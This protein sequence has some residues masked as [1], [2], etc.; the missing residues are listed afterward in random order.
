MHEKLSRLLSLRR[1][2]QRPGVNLDRAL[3]LLDPDY[4]RALLGR[5]DRHLGGAWE[6]FARDDQL[7]PWERDDWS[8]CLWLCGRGWGKT[9][10][11]AEAVR[12]VA[13]SGVTPMI[14]LIGATAADV[15]DTMVKG[16][17][18]I[19]ACADPSFMPIY[20]PSNRELVYPQNGVVIKTFSAEEPDR[21]RGGEFGFDWWDEWM[22]WKSPEEART[23]A[24]YALRYASPGWKARGIITCTPKP[25]PILETLMAQN[26]TIVIR[27]SSYDN[28]DNLSEN[29]EEM[30]LKPYEGTEIGEQEIHGKVVKAVAGAL[31]KGGELQRYRLTPDE[32][33]KRGF[34]LMVLVAVDPAASAKGEHGIVVVGIGP[35]LEK[36]ANDDQTR[37]GKLHA[38]ILVDGSIK[39]GPEDWSAQVLNLYR[40]HEATAVVAEVNNGG[41]M[42]AHTIHSAPGGAAVPVYQVHASDGKRRRAEPVAAMS[43]SKRLHLCGGFGKLE[44]QMTTWV[45]GDSSYSPDRMDAMVWGVTHGLRIGKPP[46][47]TTSGPYGVYGGGGA[48]SLGSGA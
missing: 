3:S 18:G 25:E 38:Y 21:L 7:V 30:V 26:S 10:V 19:L 17:A 11:G 27:G 13:E 34:F 40:L 4:A 24:L 6:L 31:F 29:F 8:F 42:V 44:S 16:A 1:A 33:P 37:T 28:I 46:K 32:I 43:S 35:Q 39:G 41:D 23:I 45:E 12:Q 9:R 20:N 36:W 47:K 2:L 48:P 14:R 5:G 22:A 15:R